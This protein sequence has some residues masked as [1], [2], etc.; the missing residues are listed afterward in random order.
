M[1][2]IRPV[3]VLGAMV[4]YPIVAMVVTENRRAP[5]KVQSNTM[6]PES[7]EYFEINF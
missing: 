1:Q 5:V 6:G 4:P 7:M 2:V 3:V